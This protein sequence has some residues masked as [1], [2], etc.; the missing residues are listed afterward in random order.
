MWFGE[1]DNRNTAIRVPGK[2]QSRDIPLRLRSDS[3]FVISRLTENASK[4][5]ETDWILKHGP[6]FKCITAW[7]RV[8]Q[9]ATALQWAKGHA[10][11]MGNERVDELAGEGAQ[12]EAADDEIKQSLAG[13][14]DAKEEIFDVTPTR[15]SGPWGRPILD[16]L[17]EHTE[18]RR[19]CN[20]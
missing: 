19:E 4:W 20:V 6:I 2:E 7:I 17:E 16:L 18:T 8:R 3:K 10:G 13:I 9:N 12:N 5:E 15:R 11:I 14:A 1:N